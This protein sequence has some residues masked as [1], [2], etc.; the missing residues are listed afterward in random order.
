MYG[1]VV[2]VADCLVGLYL[3]PSRPNARMYFM[4]LPD[5]PPDLLNDVSGHIFEKVRQ[6]LRS[7]CHSCVSESSFNKMEN[8]SH[9]SISDC[10]FS[11]RSFGWI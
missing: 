4:F 7:R 5:V 11:D 6:S 9:P 1:H 10:D 2:I 8:T 3:L